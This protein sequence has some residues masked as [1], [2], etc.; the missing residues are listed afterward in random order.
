MALLYLDL[1]TKVIIISYI[2]SIFLN[3]NFSPSLN[4][5]YLI[6]LLIENSSYCLNLKK[7]MFITVKLNLKSIKFLIIIFFSHELQKYH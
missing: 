7:K 5:F 6:L 2:T 3:T 4:S 1:L